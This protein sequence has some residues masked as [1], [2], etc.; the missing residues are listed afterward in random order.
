[1]CVCVTE[2][3]L[4]RLLHPTSVFSPSVT[5]LFFLFS[6]AAI[7]IKISDSDS[8]SLKAMDC[9]SS[10]L[11]LQNLPPPSIL[12]LSLPSLPRCS[13]FSFLISREGFS[14]SFWVIKM[15]AQRL[16]IGRGEEEG[17]QREAR[18]ETGEFER[19]RG[20]RVSYVMVDGFF[21]AIGQN[22]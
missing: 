18:R 15:R 5:S 21:R 3:T 2:L 11:K 10:H 14:P 8:N 9:L 17:R 13:P 16:K 22:R 12:Y 20:R 4:H 6:F 19:L 7:M 1:M